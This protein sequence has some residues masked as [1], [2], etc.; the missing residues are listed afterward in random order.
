MVELDDA[1]P[2][3]KRAKTDDTSVDVHGAEASASAEQQT[4]DA[5]GPSQ[6][7]HAS[8]VFG[9]SPPNVLVMF[10]SHATR[11]LLILLY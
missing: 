8:K 4:N 2:S 7:Q 3:A 6:Q 11:N 5:T 10:L 9:A 1:R